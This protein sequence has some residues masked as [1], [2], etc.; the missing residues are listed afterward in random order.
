MSDYMNSL[1]PYKG[2]KEISDLIDEVKKLREYYFNQQFDKMQNH[3]NNLM[4]KYFAETLTWNTANRVAP[5]TYQQSY[6]NAETFLR[7]VGCE[8]LLKN[9][10]KFQEQLSSEE[11]ALIKSISNPTE[12]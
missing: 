11:L 2:I 8:L 3:I 4:L 7:A 6:V 5:T 10:V 9:G 1:E 12:Q